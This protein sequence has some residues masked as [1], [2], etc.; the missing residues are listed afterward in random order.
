MQKPNA[1]R[2]EKVCDILAK[3]GFVEARMRGSHIV[4]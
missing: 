3:Q 1:M 4:M 2:T